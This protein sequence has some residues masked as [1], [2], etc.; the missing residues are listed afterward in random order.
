MR[1]GHGVAR[2]PVVPDEPMGGY[3]DRVGGV[4]GELE[5]LEVH[6]MV[7]SGAGTRFVLLVADLA[8]VNTD[9]VAAIRADLAERYDASCWVAATH[10]HSGPEPGCR[11]GGAPTP[12]GLAD[13]LLRAARD[14]VAVAVRDDVPATVEPPYRTTVDGLGGRRSTDTPE[15]QAVP[16]DTTAVRDAGGALL[17]LL[18][19]HP[20]HPTVLPA[21]NRDVSADLSGAIRR[22]IGR[23]L[24]GVWVMVATGAAGDLS[25][26]HTRRGRG[27]AELDRLGA[28]VADA[29]GVPPA[30]ADAAPAVHGP[31]TAELELRPKGVDDLPGLEELRTRTGAARTFEQGLELAAGLL[32]APDRPAA[33]RVRLEAV[34]LGGLDLVAVPGE[35]F[36]CLGE[37]IR[38]AAGQPDRTVVLGYANGYVGYLPNREAYA[39]PDYEVLASPVAPG[40]GEQVAEAAAAL[41]ASL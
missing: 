29:I 36:L 19:V 20:V 30:P 25:T 22:A 8:C 34:S 15:P 5:P 13:R 7:L 4:A 26:R 40:S 35:L 3:A 33:Y 11:P 6:A 16:V 14:A 38:A 32:D 41:T 31:V 37:R 28:L 1:V 9:V 2:L 17:G 27:Q 18:V 21:G 12:P 24:P 39:R 10:T 23:R